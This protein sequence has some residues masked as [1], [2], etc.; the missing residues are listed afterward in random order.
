MHARDSVRCAVRMLYSLCG[1]PIVVAACMV[2]IVQLNIIVKKNTAIKCNLAAYH[3]A[4]VQQLIS[5][6]YHYNYTT[7]MTLDL[8]KLTH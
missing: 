6:T 3:K 2:W 8:M 7:L 5:V 4:K 1:Y